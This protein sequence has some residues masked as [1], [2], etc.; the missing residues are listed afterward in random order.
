MITIIIILSYLIGAIPTGYLLVRLTAGKDIR[1]EGSGNVG[2]MNSYE[3]TGSKWVGIVTALLDLLKGAGAVLLVRKISG[4]E[5]FLTAL[6]AFFV[7]LGHNLN[8][9]LKLKG[10]RGLAP[11]AGAILAIN[12]LPVLLWGMMW[13]TGYYVIKRHVHAGNVAGTLGA[14]ILFYTT[15]DLLIQKT[16]LMPMREFLILNEKTGIMQ[17]DFSK[18]K[19]LVFLICVLIFI[20]HLKPIQELFRENPDAV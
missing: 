15:P 13:V 14:P 5:F 2:A 10:G 3:V 4:D 12:P 20:R 19:M 16:L 11:A 9:F 17:T 1:Q 6:A 7:V 18:L 8:I